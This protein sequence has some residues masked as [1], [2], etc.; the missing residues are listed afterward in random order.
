MINVSVQSTK[1]I[2]RQLAITRI[3][4][5]IRCVLERNYFELDSISFEMEK[6]TDAFVDRGI[7]FDYFNLENWTNETL[8]VK[9]DESFYRFSMFDNYIVT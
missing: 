3:K 1:N 5:I 8:S 2:S 6:D 9:M 4:E 7:E